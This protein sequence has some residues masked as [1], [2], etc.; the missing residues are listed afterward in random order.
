MRRIPRF[1]TA[2][3]VVG[4]A[5]SAVL[6]GCGGK[7]SKSTAPAN[8]ELNSGHIGSGA[9]YEHTF[10]TEGVKAYHCSIHSNMTANVDVSASAPAGDLAI[11]IHN[12]TFDPQ[13]PSVRPGAKVT[14]TN[15]D[16]TD[17][18]VTSN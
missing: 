10:S 8:L 5:S 13:N 15:N 2:A 1:I 18:T 7:S 14:W 12:F 17:H 9:Q 16:G 11:S 4:I 6:F 3:A